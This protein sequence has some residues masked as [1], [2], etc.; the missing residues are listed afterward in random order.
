MDWQCVGVCV[1]VRE[2]ERESERILLRVRADHIRVRHSLQPD[3]FLCGPNA[4]LQKYKTVENQKGV[5]I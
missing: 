5:L 4:A 3:A 2:R 1:C